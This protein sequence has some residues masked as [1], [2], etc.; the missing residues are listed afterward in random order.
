MNSGKWIAVLSVGLAASLLCTPAR[1]ENSK[2][3]APVSRQPTVGSEIKRGD[4]A[5]QVC[6]NGPKVD[7]LKPMNQVNCIQAAIDLNRQQSTLSDPFLLG[8]YVHAL[9]SSGIAVNVLK[10]NKNTKGINAFVLEYRR[11]WHDDLTRILKNDN[12]SVTDF[13]EAVDAPDHLDNVNKCESS[14]SSTLS[15]Q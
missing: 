11:L 1:T 8:L 10:I 14:V 2:L 9:A 13:C 5:A 15:G 12:L 3:D 6:W 4:A 7:V